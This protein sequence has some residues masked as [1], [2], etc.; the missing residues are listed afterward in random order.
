MT[1]R[2]YL[3]GR[4]MNK[5]L[6][7]TVIACP[8]PYYDIFRTTSTHQTA[9]VAVSHMVAIKFGLLVGLW[10]ATM[11]NSQ[12][13]TRC[14]QILLPPCKSLLWNKIISDDIRV[15]LAMEDFAFTSPVSGN[16]L[17]GSGLE[18]FM[19]DIGVFVWSTISAR[20]YKRFCLEQFSM[21]IQVVTR[22]W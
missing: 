4:S 22:N 1:S 5:L 13:N 12:R 19:N 10:L 2:G 8:C 9:F 20:C 17:R 21:P 6:H 3:W 16:H 7:I 11:V 14:N 18:R 15:E